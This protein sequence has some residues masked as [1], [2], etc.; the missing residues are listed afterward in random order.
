MVLEKANIAL[1]LRHDKCSFLF[2]ADLTIHFFHGSLDCS[3][4]CRHI[5][6]GGRSR[7]P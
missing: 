7:F 4:A 1:A 6:L 3:Y 5:Q 2:R